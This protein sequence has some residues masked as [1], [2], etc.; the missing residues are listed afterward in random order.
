VTVDA[1]CERAAEK[2]RIAVIDDDA[3]F[4][5]LMHDLLATG[6]GYHVVSNSNWV[7]GYEFVKHHGPDLVIL[8]L[9]MGREQTGWAVLELLR[10]D[11]STAHIPV[12]LCS[13]AEPSLRQHANRVEGIGPT[14]AV[15]KPFDVDHLLDVIARLVGQPKPNIVIPEFGRKSAASTTDER[16]KSCRLQA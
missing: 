7:Q 10:E 11:P 2:V 12:I 9:M 1:Q 15:S 5:E 8:D 4:V 16:P 6:E 3:V 13:A 14:E